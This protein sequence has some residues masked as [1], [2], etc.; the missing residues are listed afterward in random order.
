[1]PA[2]QLSYAGSADQ[3]PVAVGPVVPPVGDGF[4]Y[5]DHYVYDA[6]LEAIVEGRL[7][8]G[9]R[10]VLDDLAEQLK[11]SRTPIRDALARLTSEGLVRRVGRK[12]FTLTT[13]SAEEMS[14]LYDVRLMCELYAVENG[15]DDATPDLLAE[16]AELAEQGFRALRSAN[17]LAASL[18]DR[19]FHRLLVSLGHNP[20]L[21]N[22]VEQL[23]IHIQTL[24][25][26][27]GQ[28]KLEWQRKHYRLEHLAIVEAIRAR[29]RAAAKEAIRNHIVG[30]SHRAV[31][32]LEVSTSVASGR[33][34][35]SR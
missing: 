22:L 17:P 15:I 20:K 27:P 35:A 8:P 3:E 13:L 33:P 32:A 28:E 12:G 16:M 18:K 34:L 1:M 30:A 2:R 26:R 4:R 29:D 24:R 7:A 23:N 14:D 25:V 21:T 6:L 11:V 5:L 10:L 31:G 9:S 19:E